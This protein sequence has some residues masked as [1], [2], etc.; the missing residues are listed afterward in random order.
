MA[1]TSLWAVRNNLP[2]VIEYVGNAD[3][4]GDREYADL[5]QAL[6]YTTDDAKTEQK[7]YV[8]GINCTPDTVYERM[9]YSF[10]QNDRPMPV[11]AYHGYQSFA[12]G[13]VD[14][15]TAHE[16]GVK[17]A[18]ELWGDRYVALV[19]THINT[20]HIHN[21]FLLCSTSYV[22]GKRFHN[23]HA[24]RRRMAEV[25]D[26]LCLHRKRSSALICLYVSSCV[27]I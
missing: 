13:E 17:L 20:D 24:A 11:V 18:Q 12:E 5:V 1:T 15:G 25:S 19:A 9:C 26:R 2:Y 4:T 14:A 7:C 6:H 10:R 23:D 22:D 3:K 21:H 16:I 27:F 8:T